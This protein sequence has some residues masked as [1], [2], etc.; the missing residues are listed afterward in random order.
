MGAIV[1]SALQIK[2]SR[3]HGHE[4]KGE[5]VD[6][7]RGERAGCLTY[8]RTSPPFCRGISLPLRENHA[9]DHPEPEG[10]ILGFL[11][12]ERGHASR[13]VCRCIS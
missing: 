8:G 13:R 2:A 9:G 4:K 12:P 1:A 10:R 3:Q 6:G 7:F 5:V 11:A